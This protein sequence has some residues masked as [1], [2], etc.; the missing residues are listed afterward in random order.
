MAGTRQPP[1]ILAKAL[2]RISY[3]LVSFVAGTFLR[4]G[5]QAGSFGAEVRP[6]SAL[7]EHLLP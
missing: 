6:V 2:E 4:R 7:V 1:G 5:K 3:L